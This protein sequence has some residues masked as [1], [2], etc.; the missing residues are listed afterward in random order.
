MVVRVLA[1]RGLVTMIYP[2]WD[3][4]CKMDVQLT[5]VLLL[6]GGKSLVGRK[7]TQATKM[8][9]PGLMFNS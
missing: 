7:W 4:R 6:T 5:K 8:S 1:P 2:S 9:I 3:P